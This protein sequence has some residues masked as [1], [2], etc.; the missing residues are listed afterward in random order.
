MKH[1]ATQRTLTQLRV[2][3]SLTLEHVKSGCKPP[4]HNW[5]LH[6]DQGKGKML[7]GLYVKRLHLNKQVASWHVTQYNVHSRENNAQPRIGLYWVAVRFWCEQKTDSCTEA[8]NA[9]SDSL[10]FNM[11]PILVYSMQA[12]LF[13]SCL[14]WDIQMSRCLVNSPRSK[15]IYFTIMYD[16]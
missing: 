14:C 5:C 10:W 2:G 6:S 11:W 7:L 9:Y 12:M 8:S 15:D 13:Y 4:Q 16:T 3:R 1:V